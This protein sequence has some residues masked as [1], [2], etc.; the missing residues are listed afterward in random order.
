MSIEIRLIVKQ[1]RF[2]LVGLGLILGTIAIALGVLAAYFSSLDLGGDDRGPEEYASE[3]HSR[4]G[5]C[6]E[7]VRDD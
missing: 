7:H 4:A 6:L 3:N 5:H 1:Y 2:G